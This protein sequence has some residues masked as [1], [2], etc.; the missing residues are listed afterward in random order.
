M[1][2]AKR[3]I[4]VCHRNPDGDAAG[5]LLGIGLLLEQELR[6]TPVIF[7]C[8]DAVPETFHFL[9]AA[10]RVVQTCTF[11]EGDVIVFLD[12]AEPKLTGY[13]QTHPHL[14]D[15]TFSS[16]NIDHHPTNSQFATVNL[17]EPSAASSC[18]IVVM[19]ADLLGWPLTNDIATCLLTGVYTDT[20]GL[21]HSNTTAAVYRTVARLLRAG[22]RQ[23]E[24]VQA[25]FRTAKIST[26]KLWGRVLEKIILTEEGGAISAI[27]AGDFRATGAHYSALTGA[28]DYVNA[29]PG[30]RFSLILSE[31]DGAVKGS[32]R[33]LRDDV[34]VS[35]MAGKF[36]GGGHKKAAGFSL[37]GTLKPEIRWKVV[38][39]PQDS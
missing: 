34:D 14:F 6:G 25:V 11:Q 23:Q 30:M 8:L 39:P 12:A 13:H 5:A 37:P 28:I 20:G 26:L 33:T 21:L 27:T 18:E 36:K 32:L 29:V 22:A 7:H 17:V 10:Q 15:G 3:I 35:R 1:K 38:A 19:L 16:V 24:I 31:R 9:P 2:E 4:C